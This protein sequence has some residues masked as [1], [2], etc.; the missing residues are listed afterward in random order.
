MKSQD[1]TFFGEKKIIKVILKCAQRH[2]TFKVRLSS[3]APFN[4]FPPKHHS[5]KDS[6]LKESV[7]VYS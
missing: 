5:K 7:Q 1:I 3:R 6:M 4:L 2:R